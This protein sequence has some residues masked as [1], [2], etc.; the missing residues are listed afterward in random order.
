MLI[1]P[2]L[3]YQ[4]KNFKN[5]QVNICD[6]KNF[7][8]AFITSSIFALIF[9]FGYFPVIPM[10]SIQVSHIVW[11]IPCVVILVSF[12]EI[13][14]RDCLIKELAKNS[15]L[16]KTQIYSSLV[17][18]LAHCANILY[19]ASVLQTVNQV[20]IAF[21]FGMI[22]SSLYIRYQMI[23]IPILL[24]FLVNFMSELIGLYSSFQEP[25]FNFL[26][27]PIQVGPQ[28]ILPV[29]VCIMLFL[30]SQL[31]LPR[32]SLIQKNWFP[33]FPNGLLLMNHPLS[34]YCRYI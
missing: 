9:F 31:V 26:R 20:I 14:F 18:G 5:I 7:N 23:N 4:T 15:N 16:F 17:F 32:K 28:V 27:N 12:E 33:D 29:L 2:V 30:A 3:V 8:P 1:L 21:G 34:T 25:S 13:T 6:N 19:T 11:T 10:E 22:F 24:H